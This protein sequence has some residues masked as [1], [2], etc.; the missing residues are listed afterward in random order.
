MTWENCKKKIFNWKSSVKKAFIVILQLKPKISFFLPT[1]RP[2]QCG[3]WA[4]SA[5]YT[6][7]RGNT[8][9][10][11]HWVR[12]GIKST[13]SWILVGFV[14]CWA[15]V[16]LLKPKISKK[17]LASGSPSRLHRDS[18]PTLAFSPP[19]LRMDFS[20]RSSAVSPVQSLHGL[21]HWGRGTGWQSH[22]SLDCSPWS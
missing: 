13:F 15:T 2:Q 17:P 7:A 11:T 1:P 21:L 8:R 9:S 14:N 3:I 4:T 16:E 6:T 20:S 10:L 18:Q 19:P 12:P 5:T 22:K